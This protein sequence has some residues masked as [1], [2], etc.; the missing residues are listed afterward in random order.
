MTVDPA[1]FK[2]IRTLNSLTQSEMAARL[3][4]SQQLVGHIETKY[5]GISPR[6]EQRFTSEFGSDQIRY[7][8]RI[9]DAI[10]SG[11]YG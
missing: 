9:S 4:V 6:V 11:D 3:G 10:K 1:G 2:A 7:V 8:R 5:A